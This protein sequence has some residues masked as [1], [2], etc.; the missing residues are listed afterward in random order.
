MTK[1]K[2]G[3]RPKGSSKGVSKIRK[4]GRLAGK[5]GDMGDRES[6]SS[7][8]YKEVPFAVNEHVLVKPENPSEKPYVGRITEIYEKGAD[9]DPEMR[10]RWFYRPEET[11]GGRKPFHGADEVFSS[12]HFDCISAATIMR[13]CY[14]YTLEDYASCIDRRNESEFFCR[15]HYAGGRF[16]P[17]LRKEHLCVC[18]Q[19]YNP[20]KAMIGCDCCGGWFH[21]E[22]IHVA[23]NNAP[24]YFTCEQCVAKAKAKELS[25]E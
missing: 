8:V 10:M 20:D 23:E 2:G 18:Q 9:G 14:I 13:R 16:R 19:P 11:D 5:H 7:I 3:G 6:V 15:A 12:D 17:D 24:E 21:Y 4:S 1:K 25:G 22:C